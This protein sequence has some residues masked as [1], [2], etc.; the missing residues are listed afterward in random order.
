MKILHILKSEPD[1]T[2]TSIIELQNQSIEVTVVKLMG[3]EADELLHLVETHDK[4][5]MW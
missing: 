1:K 2:V 5:I 4:V 3:I